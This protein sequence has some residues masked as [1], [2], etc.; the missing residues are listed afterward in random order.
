MHKAHAVHLITMRCEE[1]AVGKKIKAPRDGGSAPFAGV[2]TSTRFRGAE[3]PNAV[4][5]HAGVAL[6]AVAQ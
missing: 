2:V 4:L 1:R 6:A 3:L 5:A